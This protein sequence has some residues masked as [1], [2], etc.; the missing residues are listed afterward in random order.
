MAKPV[1]TQRIEKREKF[2]RD[3]LETLVYEIEPRLVRKPIKLRPTLLVRL[4]SE[5]KCFATI[6]FGAVIL[7]TFKRVFKE[8]LMHLQCRHGLKV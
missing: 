6:Q 2:L 4:L 8:E 1:D 5:V 7:P 3:Q